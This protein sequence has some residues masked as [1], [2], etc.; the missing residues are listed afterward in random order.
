MELLDVILDAISKYLNPTV[1]IIGGL[2]IFLAAKKDKEKS[3]ACGSIAMAIGVLGTFIGISD[4]LSEFNV[5]EIS[6]SIPGLLDGM[7]F[8]F[9]TSILG[10]LIS[11]VLR[12]LNEIIEKFTVTKE[13]EEVDNVEDL[14][15]GLL[16]EMKS[17][18]YTLQKN[19]DK[20]DDVVLKLGKVFEE[21]QNKLNS[22]LKSLND[23]LNEKQDILIDE[24]RGLNTSLNK[25]QDILINEFREF[26]ESMAH[27]NTTAL[28]EAL[29]GVIKE[30]N[31]NLTEQFGENFKELNLAVSKL[32]EWQEYYKETVEVNTKQ[33]KITVDSIKSIDNA[34]NNI[35]N[36]S[37]SL[38]RTSESVNESLR[39]V[40][41][42]Q[43]EV[44]SGVSLI[45]D[46]SNQAKESIPS[47][48]NYFEAANNNLV[49][50]IEVLDSSLE[51]KLVAINK[52]TKDLT[53]TIGE[54]STESMSEITQ[55]LNNM[56]S[57]I[58]QEV[59]GYVKELEG[60][61]MAINKTIPSIADEMNKNYALFTNTLESVSTDT[62]N[63]LRL[64]TEQIKSQ[65]ETLSKT[66]ADL[67]D[68]LQLQIEEINE[69]TSK[70]I[71]QI[72][73][74]MEKLFLDRSNQVN[75]MLEHELKESLNSLGTQL[76]TLS[77]RFV[78]DYTPLTERLKEVVS[79]AQGV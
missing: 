64:S 76:A 7:K 35:S 6:A 11:I 67:R 13:D 27:N 22:E 41:L 18:N 65:C 48:N 32:L 36:S 38:I 60:L 31:N 45:T 53:K 44:R 37:D 9:E 54:S 24:F 63:V 71:V 43:D 29:E 75:D 66:N 56:N 49:K 51:T 40:A 72:V 47:L 25:K 42:S 57:N 70:Q 30:F 1:W 77:G 62:N 74:Q 52:Y 10:M 4:G 14:F 21:N 39:Q 5:D 46:V 55:T 61:T 19:Q 34:L 23:S 73:E 2:G 3:N 17:L 69:S 79:I 8:A 50:S 58:K 68:K 12:V 16:S 59:I 15:N 26:G 78:E 28:I 20:T 33:L